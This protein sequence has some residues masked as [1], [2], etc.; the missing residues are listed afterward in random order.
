[1][2]FSSQGNSDRSRIPGP[3]GGPTMKLGAVEDGTRYHDFIRSVLNEK[4]P[5]VSWAFM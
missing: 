4:H 1:M 5:P 3:I 2:A